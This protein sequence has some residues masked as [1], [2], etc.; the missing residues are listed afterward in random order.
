MILEDGFLRVK[1]RKYMK[2][3]IQKTK[4]KEV[5]SMYGRMDACMKVTLTM[6]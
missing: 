1:N 4:S 3:S 6:T 5:E 2:V